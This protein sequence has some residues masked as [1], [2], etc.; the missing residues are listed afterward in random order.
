MRGPR[1]LKEG[2]KW[3]DRWHVRR[4]GRGSPGFARP[5]LLAPPPWCG[6]E[7]GGKGEWRYCGS[8][9][10]HGACGGCNPYVRFPCIEIVLGGA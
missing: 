4:C 10:A 1:N 2:A 9:H 3:C 6:A 8:E 7:A 5:V